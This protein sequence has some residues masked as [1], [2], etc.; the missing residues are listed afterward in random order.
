MAIACKRRGIHYT[1]LGTGCIFSYKKDKP[2]YEFTEADEPNFF[3]SSYS[4]VKGYTDRLMHLFGDSVLNLRI[5]M[6]IVGYDHAR[7]FVTKIKMYE[8]IIDVPNSMTVLPEMLPIALDL[9]RR[10]ITGTI[11]LTNPGVISHNDILK[12]YKKHVDPSFTWTN[13]TVEEQNKILA[14]ER[15]NNKLSTKR[16]EK[17][18]AVR[19]IHEAID[20]LMRT[21][22]VDARFVRAQKTSSG[23]FVDSSDTIL[24]VT[25]GA[26]FIGSNFIIITQ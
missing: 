5:R 1:Y 10:R 23:H 2:S 24:F 25:G 20:S 7:N 14:C 18:V 22:E 3:G 21:Y 13:F 19:P 11:N 26:G 12:L 15:S 8:K 17:L 9:I 6:P 4:C 16:L